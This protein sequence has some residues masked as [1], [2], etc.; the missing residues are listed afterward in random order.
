M[1]EKT[2]TYE[3]K[4]TNTGGYAAYLKGHLVG[5]FATEN[6]TDVDSY[7]YELGFYGRRDLLNYLGRSFRKLGGDAF[8]ETY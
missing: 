2:L 3:F 4:K 5:W 1:E 7:I 8:E 6:E